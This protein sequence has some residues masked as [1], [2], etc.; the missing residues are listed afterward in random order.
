MSDNDGSGDENENENDV[1]DEQSSDGTTRRRTRT[2]TRTRTSYLSDDDSENENENANSNKNTND[3]DN[4]SENEVLIQKSKQDTIYQ[5]ILRMDDLKNAMR[6]ARSINFD[7]QTQIWDKLAEAAKKLLT[8]GPKNQRAAKY[9]R[10]ISKE[11]KLINVCRI[12]LLNSKVQG[13]HKVA[14]SNEAQALKNAKINFLLKRLQEEDEKGEQENGKGRKRKRRSSLLS[15]NSSIDESDGDNDDEDGAETP[16]IHQRFYLSTN[17]MGNN[18]S[19]DMAPFVVND[20]NFERDRIIHSMMLSPV[21]MFDFHLQHGM[22]IKDLSLLH[23]KLFK[24]Y[25]LKT[26]TTYTSNASILECFSMDKR[27]IARLVE[28]AMNPNICGVYVNL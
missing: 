2:R 10:V 13:D 12:N 3:D 6:K 16:N 17:D 28:I 15:M 22:T 21:I 25:K 5:C 19:A 27:I 4:D 24:P 18:I 9:S 20:K 1:S 7:D 8:N 14:S 26:L 23:H 11:I